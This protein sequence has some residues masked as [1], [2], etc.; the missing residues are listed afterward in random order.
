MELLQGITECI[1]KEKRLQPILL[2]QFLLGLEGCFIE[3][4]WTKTKS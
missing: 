4:N 3:Q 2:H 1:N